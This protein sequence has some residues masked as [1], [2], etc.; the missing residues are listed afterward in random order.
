MVSGPAV[1]LD[2]ASIDEFLGDGGTGV[3][4]LAREDDPYSIPVSYG[5]DDADR[6]FYVR[7]GYTSG[8]EKERFV[9]DDATARLVVYDRRG[10]E[11]VS[12]VAEGRLEAVAASDVDVSVVRGLRDAALPVR[13]VFGVPP[14]DVE[15]RIYAL[16]VDS[17]AG[18][19]APASESI[20]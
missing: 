18:R 20:E 14:E 1:R 6:R 13:A 7:L 19:R 4:S 5:Y 3:L 2:D 15:F 9:R 10:D 11:W 16:A 12:V 17:L 8:T